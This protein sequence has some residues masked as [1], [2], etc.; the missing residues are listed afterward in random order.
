[1]VVDDAGNFSSSLDTGP[2]SAA[3]TVAEA[4]GYVNLIGTYK[5]TKR[6]YKADGSLHRK[7]RPKAFRSN[8]LGRLPPINS[9]H[10]IVK[11]LTRSK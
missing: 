9:K 1:M 8:I 6:Y 2:G 4:D 3:H 5:A 10:L 11:N 7:D